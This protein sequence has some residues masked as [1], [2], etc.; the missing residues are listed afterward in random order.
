LDQGSIAT[1]LSERKKTLV[2]QDHLLFSKSEATLL[3]GSL[4]KMLQ[5]GALQ[6]QMQPARSGHQE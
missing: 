1:P 4:I 6:H 2:G 3:K 5:N